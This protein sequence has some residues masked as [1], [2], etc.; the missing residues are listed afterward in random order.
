MTML[1]FPAQFYLSC[2]QVKVTGGGNGSPS[3][4]VSI[5]GVYTGNEPGILINIY[6]RK[7]LHWIEV[8]NV[9]DDS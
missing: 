2:A 1:T 3:P 6:Y 8:D 7:S 4:L 5:P 9:V